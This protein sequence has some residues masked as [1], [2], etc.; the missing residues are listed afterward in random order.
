M[1]PG[2]REREQRRLEVRYIAKARERAR[3]V[4][5]RV[6]GMVSAWNLYLCRDPIKTVGGP[7]PIAWEWDGPFNVALRNRERAKYR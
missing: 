2:K 1:R 5:E 3:L 7:K 6:S 4:G